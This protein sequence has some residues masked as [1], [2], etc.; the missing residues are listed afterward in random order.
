M[1]TLTAA[2][3]ANIRPLDAVNIRTIDLIAGATITRGQAIYEDSNGLAQLAR[4]NAVG[5]AKVAGIATVDAVA[6]KPVT[7]LYQGR[8]VG[9]DLSGV[10]AGTTVYLS[11]G[12][13][14]AIDGAAVTGT[15]NV[16]VPLGT[17]RTM[18]DAPKTKYI[19]FTIPQNAVPVA[20]P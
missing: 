10:N 13:A 12:T 18:T 14:G 16:A 9:W 8:L 3:A 4:G 6:G 5:T 15:G 2:S 11:S 20:L 1:A 19:L 7:V 17:V